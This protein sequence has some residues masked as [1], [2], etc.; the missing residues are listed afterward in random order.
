MTMTIADER[1]GLQLEAGRAAPV[2]LAAS[3]LT[4]P[5]RFLTWY[6]ERQRK[7]HTLTQI[8]ELADWQLHDIGLDR[9]EVERAMFEAGI[10]RDPPRYFDSYR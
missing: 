6:G 2:R 1:F 9:P 7:R 10:R 8:S 4:A 3:L 5:F